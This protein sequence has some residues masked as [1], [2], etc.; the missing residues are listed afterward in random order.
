MRVATALSRLAPDGSHM[1]IAVRQLRAVARMLEELAS[2]A[3]YHANA[4]TNDA[5]GPDGPPTPEYTR[6]QTWEDRPRL[7]ERA[8]ALGEIASALRSTIAAAK[9]GAS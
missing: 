2:M 7:L 1:D 9:R 4:A 8:A 5:M 3:R 6:R